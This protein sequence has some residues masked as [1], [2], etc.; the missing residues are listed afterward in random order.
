LPSPS[1]TSPTSPIPTSSPGPVPVP[2][3]QRS[4]A[5]SCA[6]LVKPLQPRSPLPRQF[7]FVVAQLRVLIRERARLAADDARPYP[8]G[9]RSAWSQSGGRNQRRTPPE[10]ACTPTRESRSTRCVEEPRVRSA[11]QTHARRLQSECNRGHRH[12]PRRQARLRTRRLHACARILGE[13]AK[14]QIH[15][16]RKVAASLASQD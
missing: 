4:A 5:A 13:Y 7:P 11:L 16:H 12:C 14:R 9:V 10:A 1:P 8:P 3:V 2:P 6:F 15:R